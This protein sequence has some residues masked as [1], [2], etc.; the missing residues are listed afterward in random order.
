[1][2]YVIFRRTCFIRA[3]NSDQLSAKELQVRRY[4]LHYPGIPLHRYTSFSV[5]CINVRVFLF[6]NVHGPVWDL[7]EIKCTWVELQYG[8]QSQKQKG[9]I[10][11][12]MHVYNRRDCIRFCLTLAHY[13]LWTVLVYFSTYTISANLQYASKAGVSSSSEMP[14]TD[15]FCY[16][17]FIAIKPNLCTQRTYQLE[18]ILALLNI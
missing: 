11:S 3:Q 14:M 10:T 17:P 1:M 9:W 8:R 12:L 2:V 18:Y 7:G 16:S 6:I 4:F 13:E 15:P 5:T